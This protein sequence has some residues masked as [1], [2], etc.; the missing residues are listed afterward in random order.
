L[1]NCL[2][3]KFGS[4]RPY[5]GLFGPGTNCQEWS[6]DILNECRLQCGLTPEPY[7]AAVY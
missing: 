7:P 1:E 2:R 3:G 6:N 5:Y 4:G